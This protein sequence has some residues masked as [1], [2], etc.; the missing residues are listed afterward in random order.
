MYLSIT[1]TIGGMLR[2]MSGAFYDLNTTGFQATLANNVPVGETCVVASLDSMG[3]IIFDW[4]KFARE[5]VKPDDTGASCRAFFE[6]HFKLKLFHAA[7]PCATAYTR[8][9]LISMATSNDTRF[10]ARNLFISGLQPKQ[11]VS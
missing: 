4:Y 7:P 3:D 1:A 2:C 9:S 8:T 5:T 6:D 11:I 10:C